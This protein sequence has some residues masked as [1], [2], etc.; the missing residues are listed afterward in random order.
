LAELEALGHSAAS[1]LASSVRWHLRAVSDDERT[2]LARLATFRGPVDPDHALAVVAGPGLGVEATSRA[3][4][5]LVE[6]R[7]LRVDDERLVLDRRL[8]EVIHS[9]RADED[10]R[11]DHLL[12][13]VDRF[14]GVAEAFDAAGPT[15][16]VSWLDDDLDDV[17]AALRI[18]CDRG[19]PAAYRLAAALGP[20][21][22]E[23][24]RWSELEAISDWLSTRSPTDGEL[25]WVAAVARVSFA[26]S[27]I[28]AAAVHALR[29]EA[30]AI[31][32]LDHDEVSAQFLTFAAAS[33]AL[34]RGV[35]GPARELFRRAAAIGNEPVATAIA[36]RLLST[37]IGPS[38]TEHAA[39]LEARDAAEPVPSGPTETVRGHRCDP[40]WAAGAR[41]HHARREDG[42][43]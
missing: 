27:G 16:P 7:L 1:A 25:A 39:Y 12:R 40:V 5:G 26:A 11:D 18:A 4:D 37:G 8:L 24:D 20:H 21:W 36:A 19:T 35:D 22:H 9:W 3:L 34:E 23:L 38:T 32:A 13:Y 41:R 28:P 33:S 10:G 14:V 2:V 6:R 31:A 42:A 17:C 15:V 43:R 29:D 30:M